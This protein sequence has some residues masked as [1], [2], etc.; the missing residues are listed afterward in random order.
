MNYSPK[1]IFMPHTIDID[2]EVFKQLTLRR[3][4][5]GVTYNDVLRELLGIKEA[6][7][8]PLSQPVAATAFIS[9]GVVFPEGT[10]FR[11]TL[12]GKLHTGQVARRSLLVDG[13]HYASL[14]AAGVALT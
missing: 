4:H 8:E 7:K 12:K 9:K 3:Q 6:K 13:K 2:F 5:E 11:A 1:G 14:S 10:K